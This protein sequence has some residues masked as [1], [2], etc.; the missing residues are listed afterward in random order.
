MS[1]QQHKPLIT[2]TESS[3]NEISQIMEDFTVLYH[4]GAL[5]DFSVIVGTTTV[6][7][8]KSILAARCSYFKD[9]F[10]KN[11]DIKQLNLPDVDPIHFKVLTDYIYTAKL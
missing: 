6:K 10:T 7:L 9:L 8:H 1:Q 3:N 2:I 5:S 4:S 11:P